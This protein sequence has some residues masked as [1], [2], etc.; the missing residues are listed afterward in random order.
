MRNNFVQIKKWFDDN[1]W[2][3]ISSVYLVILI[4]LI[5]N[6][7]H[8]SFKKP[9]APS[10]DVDVTIPLISKVYTMAEIA[11]DESILSVDSTGL[12]ALEFESELDTYY[13]RDQL[14]L[15]QMQENFSSELGLFTIASPGS[16]SMNMALW[17]IFSQAETFHGTTTVV[18]PFSFST[19]RRP[20][21]SY[22]NFSY[23]N[24]NTGSVTL[25]VINNLA[26]PLGSPLNLEIWNTFADTLISSITRSVQVLPGD[27]TY[28]QL[29]L[30]QKKMPNA[31]SLRFSG[32]SPGSQGKLVYVDKNSS[33]EITAIISE[34]L[35]SEA[36][37]Q[38]PSQT[39]SRQDHVT[40]TDSLV[41]QEAVIEAGEIQFSLAGSLPLDAMLYY[42]LPDFISPSGKALIDSI[43]IYKNTTTDFSIDLINHTLQPQFE[44]FGLQTIK[45]FWSIKTVDTGNNM[46]LVKSTDFVNAN[47]ILS[48]IQFSQFSGKVGS[49]KI[50]VNQNDIEFDIPAELDSIYLET[51]CMELH[52]NNGINFPAKTDLKIEGQ[53]ETGKVVELDVK[54]DI[55]PAIQPS[56]P[57]TSVIVL[58]Q[59]N[60][61]IKDFISILP[62]F[63][64]VFGQVNIG[65][66]TWVGTVSKNDFVNGTVKIS[67]PL[68]LKLPPQTIESDV[69]GVDIDEDT[70]EDI[71]K[72]L[73][74]GKFYAEVKNHLPLGASVEFVFA[75]NDSTI[76]Q[77]PILR[78]GPIGVDA[79]SRDSFGFVSTAKNSE[80]NLNLTEDDMRTFLKSP[81]YVGLRILLEGTNDEFIRVRAT[82]YLEVKSY[83]K[84]NIKIN[85]KQD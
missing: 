57:V 6:V 55:Q 22:E 76:Y 21:N 59:Q 50:E 79:A 30:Q 19:D 25:E 31:L 62:N 8:C 54:G 81:L 16:E 23:V 27:T 11:E 64:R 83:G 15:E 84:I 5:F 51:A 34:L 46:V 1:H 41:V 29:S 4:F 72:N 74:S 32:D 49:R 2:M 14:N 69:N 3:A 65:D 12:L 78:I 33:F 60:S 35:V 82:D 17:E 77:N 71:D 80:I 53:N 20:L 73:S 45:F 70:K 39:V 28:F 13:V 85:P 68:A 43:P 10:W 67:A 36:L 75:Q 37:A 26:V 44:E 61:N 42:E 9:S 56:I 66:D 47:I 63:I 58:D 7:I 52:I 48:N 24:I 18:P 40:I 38:V